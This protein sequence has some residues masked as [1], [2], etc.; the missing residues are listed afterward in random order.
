MPSLLLT[1]I[2]LRE[3]MLYGSLLDDVK[4]FQSV[5]GD[6]GAALVPSLDKD[7][8]AEASITVGEFTYRFRADG[9]FQINR[10]LLGELISSAVA[11]ARG[12]T[13]ID[14]YCGAGLFTLPLARRF[15]SVIGI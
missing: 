2:D 6:E 8:S 5:A 10:S 13:A 12:E 11:D 15:H 14:L 7:S 1:L 4:E 9:F 3:R